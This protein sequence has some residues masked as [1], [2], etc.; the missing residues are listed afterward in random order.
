M[1]L[2]WVAFFAGRYVGVGFA[3]TGDFVDDYAA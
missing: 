1:K 3:R 2:V